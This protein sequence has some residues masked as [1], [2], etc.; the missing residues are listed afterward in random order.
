MSSTLHR[1]KGQIELYKFMV[2]CS[3]NGNSRKQLCLKIE[4]TLIF[5]FFIRP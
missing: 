5:M 4:R 3:R 1:K 2:L